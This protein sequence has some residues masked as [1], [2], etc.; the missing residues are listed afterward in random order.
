MRY[1]TIIDVSTIPEIY[2][3]NN[4]VRLYVHLCLRSGYHDYNRDAY[5]RSIRG[6]ALEL[7][8]TVSAVRHAIKILSSFKLI[9]QKNGIWLVRKYISDQTITPRKKKTNNK[10]KELTDERLRNQAALEQRLK[11]QEENAI[12]Y[13][14]Y[15][16]TKLP[17]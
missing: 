6:L 9:T 2:R 3:N 14:E 11:A 4:A 17:R 1:T 7:G 8:M 16:K 10:E 15:L 5:K 13:E 12:T